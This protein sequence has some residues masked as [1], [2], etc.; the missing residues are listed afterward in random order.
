MGAEP[1]PVP[2]SFLLRFCD[3]FLQDRNI[4]WLLMVGMLILLGSSLLLV[5]AHW[6]TYTPVWKYAIFLT[7]TATI[8]GV[9]Q[10][11]RHRLALRRTAT[12][13]QALTVLLV[14]ITFVVLHWVG[15]EQAGSLGQG[16]QLAL[17]GVNL[18]LAVAAARTIF[19]HFLRGHQPTF[20]ASYLLL[21]VAGALVPGLPAAWA[22]ML[23]LAL[24]AVFAAGSVKVNRHVFWLTE[25]HRA[26][27]ICGFLPIALLGGQFLMLFLLH[28]PQTFA[29]EWFGLGA[30]LVAVPVLLT[31]DAVA[32]VFQRRTGDLVR[33]L[34]WSIV[35]PLVVGLVLCAGGV[36]VSAASVLPPSRPH[37]L[38]LTAA[39]AAGLM[40]VVAR[41]T[42]KRAFVWA[43]LAGIVLAYNFSPV[44]FMDTARVVVAH[45]AEVIHEANLPY[46]FYGL[47][48]LPLLLALMFVA[49]VQTRGGNELFAQPLRVFAVGLASVMLAVSTGH[50]KAFVP[51]ALVMT[52]TFA[53]QAAVFRDGRLAWLAVLSWIAAASGFAEFAGA[54]LGWSL[55]AGAEIGCLAAAALALLAVGSL[56]DGWSARLLPAGIDRDWGTA[57]AELWRAPCRSASLMLAFVLG[58]LWLARQAL[59]P[60]DPSAWPIGV[61]VIGLVVAQAARRAARPAL[62]VPLFVLVNWQVISLTVL[63]F[64]PPVALINLTPLD[65]LG[66]CLPVALA[67]AASLLTW[68]LWDKARLSPW[69]EIVATHLWALRAVA[70]LALCGTLSFQMHL[71][72]N[73]IGMAAATF[74]LASAAELC[75]ACR[76]QSEA[77]VWG[78]LGV[79]L[80][81]AGYFAFFGLVA[82]GRGVAMFSVLGLG[83]AMWLIGEWVR[84]RSPFGILRRPLQQVALVLPLATVGLGI[85]RHLVAQ[86]AWLGANSLALLLAAGFYFWRGLERPSKPLLILSGL[87]LDVAMFLLWRELAW[88]DPQFFMIPIGIS[89]LALV[90]LLKSEIPERFHDPLRYLGALV[91][92]VSPT[93][94]IVGG[95]W[96]HLFSLMV[97][98]VGIVL[99]AMGLRVRALIYTGTAFLLA[100][101]VAMVVRGSIDNPNVLWMAG[102]ALGGA[103]I[104][105]AAVC[106]RNREALMGRIRVLADALKEWE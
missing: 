62:R 61:L 53:L 99:L 25:E 4:K 82:L 47:T 72:P 66:F 21:A 95:S 39:L 75:G 18:V 49:R 24:W 13:L 96:L 20:L 33:P 10:W 17:G 54:V 26:P 12:V 29:L 79:A 30:V 48:Y 22:P 106:E 36:I 65:C 11:A 32:W 92:L 43:M 59:L 51:V 94:H 56:I 14:P 70:V 100:D 38:V 37:A 28:A 15:R 105:L 58:F 74:L 88:T 55:P 40:A 93:F 91:I 103:V 67:A 85:Y 52:A 86:P 27:R 9:G 64:G 19:H 57:L 73:D 83:F 80:A 68:Q 44:F 84:D 45:S 97:A 50:V 90:Q 1:T 46:A 101:L 41:R 16:L 31:A 104:A 5:S 69:G 98:S 6:D 63:L 7:Y 60:T 102:L 76:R 34:P 78:A 77:R 2:R 87:V 23:V 81:A 71:A 3:S 89:I 42:G 35:G 8:F